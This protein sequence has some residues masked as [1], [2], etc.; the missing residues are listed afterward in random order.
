[1]SEAETKTATL[2][3]MP[4]CNRCR[5]VRE[6]LVA[7]GYTVTERELNDIIIGKEK[8]EDALVQ[9]CIQ[10]MAAPVVEINGQF[11]KPEEILNG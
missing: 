9:L 10:L 4:D 8:N 6:A 5:L 1:M 7:Q 2:W 3:Q 11:V